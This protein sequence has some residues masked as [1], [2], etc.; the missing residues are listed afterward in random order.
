LFEDLKAWVK[1]YFAKHQP[2]TLAWWL[3]QVKNWQYGDE[4]IFT[5]GVWKYETIDENKRIVKQVAVEPQ[6][7]LLVFKVAK[8]SD[9][10]LI[11]LAAEEL[12]ST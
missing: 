7:K 2:G 6:G 12:R 5:D 8:E 9:T 1:D 11:P 10:G 3:D 4:L